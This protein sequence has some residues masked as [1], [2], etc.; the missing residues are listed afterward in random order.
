MAEIDVDLNK[1]SDQVTHSLANK[2]DAIDTAKKS[3]HQTT[4]ANKSKDT[5]DPSLK[6][7]DINDAKKLAELGGPRNAVA[8]ESRP[9][10]EFGT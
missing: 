5:T 3:R 2:T 1:Q 4:Q 10:T 8:L 6:S 7:F 9:K